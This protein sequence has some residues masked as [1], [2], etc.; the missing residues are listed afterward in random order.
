MLTEHGRIAVKLIAWLFVACF[1]VWIGYYRGLQDG[2]KNGV[3]DQHAYDVEQVN[4]AA[5]TL[6]KAIFGN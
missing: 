1:L 6:Y 3:S 5:N 2:Y 4:D